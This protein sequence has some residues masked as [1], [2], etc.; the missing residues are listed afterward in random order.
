MGMVIEHIWRA[1]GGRRLTYWERTELNLE[2]FPIFSELAPPIPLWV[3]CPI[4]HAQFPFHTSFRLHVRSP[5]LAQLHLHF[6]CPCMCLEEMARAVPSFSPIKL[7]LFSSL[8][9]LNTP[10]LEN[11]PKS[12]SRMVIF[13]NRG[14]AAWWR[15]RGEGR[16][17][18][19]ALTAKDNKVGLGVVFLI[20]FCF[21]D[22]A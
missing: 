7:W 3:S 2:D 4:E 16:E 5:P 9:A 13:R 21:W 14:G 19:M 15:A 10:S 12:S 20:K 11:T 6:A 1:S 17:Q 22:N 18:G 8:N